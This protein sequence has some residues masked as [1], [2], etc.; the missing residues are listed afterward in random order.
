MDGTRSE[1]AILYRYRFG[2]AEFDEASFELKVGGLAVEL[3]RRPLEVLAL[4]LRHAGEVVT[5]E[6]LLETVWQGRITVENVLANA[7]AKLRKGL[8]E[9]LA[10][11]IRTQAR[12][13]Y[14][15][16]APV[17]RVASGRRLVNTLELKAGQPVPERSHFIL[18][19]QLSGTRGSEVWLARHEKT[20]EARVYKFSPDG[21]RLASLKREATLARVLRESLGERDDIAR[22]IDWNFETAPFFLECEYGGENLFVWAGQEDRLAA[23]LPEDRLQLALQAVDVVAAAHEAGVLHKDLKPANFLVAPRKGGEGWQVRIADFGA[24]GLLDQGR[25]DDLGITPMGMTVEEGGGSSS[26]LGT[27]LYIAPEIISGQSPSARSDVYALGV[28]LYQILA[29]SMKKPLATGWETDIPDPLLQ[30]DIAE[31]THG[32]P[33]RRI[34]SAGALASRLRALDVRR[35]EREQ[36]Q[37]LAAEAEIARA[38]LEKVKTRR[39]WVAATFAAL[40][41]GFGASLWLY[42]QAA[43]A[44][45]AAETEAARAEATGGFLRDLLVNA[46]PY[47]PGGAGDVTVR[48]ALDKASEG[49]AERFAGDPA[50]EASIQ[51]TAG[52]I[53]SSLA[54]YDAASAHKSRAA[55][56]FTALY[57]AND[58]RTLIARYRQAEAL[59]NASKLEEAAAILDEADRRAAPLL[60]GSSLLAFAATQ[61]RGRYFLVQ[62]DMENATPLLEGAVRLLPEAMPDNPE[63]SYRLK[64]DLAQVYS[65]VSRHEEAIALLADLQSPA[66]AEAGVSQAVRARALMFYG[67]S[68]FYDARYEEAEPVL[69]DAI[70]ALTEVFG[71]ESSQVVEAQNTLANLYATSGNWEPALPLVTEVRQKMCALHGE[72]HLTCLMTMGNEAVFQWFLG[73]APGAVANLEPVVETFRTQ[74]GP[75]SPAVHVLA[76]YLAMAKLEVGGADEAMALAQPL[77][78]GKLAAGSPGDDWQ[79][80]IDGL[81]GMAL[82]GQGQ[83]AEGLALLQPAVKSMQAGG[84]QPW[85]LEDY[86]NALKAAPCGG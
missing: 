1:E 66:Y 59:S 44:R 39:P 23:M 71:A 41:I 84:M 3:E 21:A 8:G 25:L 81:K 79:L 50:T 55:D 27:P 6:E 78:A 45:A 48:A 33:A 53:Y 11:Q 73:D 63:A 10:D 68:L 40:V 35:A 24:G 76:Y 14:R 60:P 69:K 62:A 18:R 28:M 32:D 12:I 5:K 75:D 51:E 2:A 67:A 20:G 61:T 22:V 42:T 52:E 19:E 74:L 86:E 72:G 16:T 54:A 34:A 43:S 7:V 56:L 70:T 15:L 9:T 58:V 17:E 4:L 85:I 77:D 80:R 49:I 29:G 83:C 46:D 26:S 37:R 30:A 47:R 65:R 13:G 38:E 64:M 57:G 31:A 36:A 82:I